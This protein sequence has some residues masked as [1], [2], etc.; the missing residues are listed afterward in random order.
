MRPAH[1]CSALLQRITPVDLTLSNKAFKDQSAASVGTNVSAVFP[2]ICCHSLYTLPHCQTARATADEVMRV[3][4]T[5]RGPES[6]ASSDIIGT[7]TL[8]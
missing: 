6:S 2:V 7:E 5:G 1:Y 3:V 8:I 4:S